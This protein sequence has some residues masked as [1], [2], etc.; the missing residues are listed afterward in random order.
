M[1]QIEINRMND[2][3]DNIELNNNKKNKVMINSN[4]NLTNNN[5]IPTSK[6]ENTYENINNDNNNS[7]K[8]DLTQTKVI[9]LKNKIV[10]NENE[11]SKNNEEKK[12]KLEDKLS[13]DYPKTCKICLEPEKDKKNKLINPCNCTGSCE[14]IHEICLK[15]WINTYIEQ[16]NTE[17]PRCEICGFEYYL[18]FY[19]KME[20]NQEK[21]SDAYKKIA[22]EFV[23][24]LILITAIIV[25][26]CLI[27]CKMFIKKK[28]AQ[29]I[30]I[31]II[32]F[33]G[34][35]VVLLIVYSKNKDWKEKCKEKVVKAWKVMTKSEVEY[36]QKSHKSEYDEE[37]N[38]MRCSLD[39]WY[40]FF[41]KDLRQIIYLNDN[42]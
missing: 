32:S 36:L 19:L 35:I 41:I 8:N 1:T 10:K 15:H 33:I 12:K 25:I 29:T 7:F 21:K 42:E 24:Y 34:I 22:L 13:D 9:V 4:D 38:E 18:K 3:S 37:L 2:E 14:Y 6:E 23:L 26:I 17:A 27:I 11:S 20:I 40:L 39:D 5:N 31:C 28:T 30:F 16:G